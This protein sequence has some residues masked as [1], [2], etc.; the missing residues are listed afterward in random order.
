[1]YRNIKSRV[2]FN[3]TLDKEFSS[4]VGVRQGECLSPFLSSMYSYDFE[5]E[6]MQNMLTVLT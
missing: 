6:L 4:Y 2:K 1:M 5:S 3:N